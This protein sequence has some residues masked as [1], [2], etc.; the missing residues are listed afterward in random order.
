MFDDQESEDE[1]DKNVPA[2]VNVDCVH[3]VVES[4]QSFKEDS[5]Q[6]AGKA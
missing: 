2:V 4:S 3:K 6:S 1:E 5:S